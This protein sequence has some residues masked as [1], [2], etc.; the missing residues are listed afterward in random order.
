MEQLPPAVVNQLEN[1]FPGAELLEAEQDR[2]RG[3]TEYEVTL[4]YKDLTLEVEVDENGKI[5]DV[6]SDS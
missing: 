2:K 1:Y 5:T 4:R 3:N 6:D